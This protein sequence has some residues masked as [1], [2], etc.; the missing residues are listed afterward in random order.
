MINSPVSE[1]I[2]HHLNEAGDAIF[3]HRYLRARAASIS[4]S[5]IDIGTVRK[6][7]RLTNP[8]TYVYTVASSVSLA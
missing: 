5:D 7:S 2:M 4:R 3:S 1:F 6:N 8:V